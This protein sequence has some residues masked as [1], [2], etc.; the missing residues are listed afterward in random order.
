SDSRGK[1]E[2]AVDNEKPKTTASTQA[3][4]ASGHQGLNSHGTDGEK[5]PLS[6]NRRQKNNEAAKKSRDARR[7]KEDSVA[8]KCALLEAEHVQ[9]RLEMAWLKNETA[10]LRYLLYSS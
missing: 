3:A 6:E 1:S 9:L 2:A 4:A 5:A 8:V 7:A 10:R